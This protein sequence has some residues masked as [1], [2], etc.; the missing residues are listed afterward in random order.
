[1]RRIFRGRTPRPTVLPPEALAAA[2]ARVGQDALEVDAARIRLA[3]PAMSVTLNGI[4]EGYITDRV[5]D[6]LRAGGVEHAMV[7]MGEIY[8]LGT[9]RRAS[10]GPSVSRTRGRPGGS[11]SDSARRSRGGDIGRLWH[12]V[13]SG[14]PIQSSVRAANGPHQLALAFRFGG[15]G[16]HDRGGRAFDRFQRDAGR[17]D[18]APSFANS[19]WSRIS[20]A[21]M[22]RVSFRER[23][24]TRVLEGQKMGERSPAW[25]L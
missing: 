7:N 11:T 9:I 18:R 4:G 21:P 16:D 15:G 22:A 14:R 8:A 5:V 25:D 13:R 1:M 2:V 3:R 20:S 6:L 23:S 19:G 10:P 17:G 24:G 12:T